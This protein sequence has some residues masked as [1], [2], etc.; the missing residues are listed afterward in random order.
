MRDNL[1]LLVKM[2]HTCMSVHA[3]GGFRALNAEFQGAHPP[4]SNPTG[5]ESCEF[6]LAKQGSKIGKDKGRTRIRR[7][8]F[9]LPQL[10]ITCLDCLLAGL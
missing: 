1:E 8:T 10:R 2:H 7:P 3:K 4:P 6:V 9:S 5:R